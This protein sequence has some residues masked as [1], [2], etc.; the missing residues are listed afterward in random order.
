MSEK[1]SDLKKVYFEPSTIE[2]IDQS[3]LDYIKNLDLRAETNKGFTRV[4]VLWATSER[5]FL[6]KEEKEI[7]DDQGALIFPLISI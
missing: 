4:P 2:S 7:R 3:I 5:S 1:Y 6:S